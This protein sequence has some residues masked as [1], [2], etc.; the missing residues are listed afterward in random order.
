[1]NI[2]N[3]FSER[4]ETVLG[5]KI[6]QFFDADPDPGSG[7]EKF[8]SGIRGKHPGSAALLKIVI[9]C[10]TSVMFHTSPLCGIA[11][12]HNPIYQASI[13]SEHTIIS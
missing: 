9:T 2:P 13:Q 4:L 7:M 8:G 1:M 10:I 3:R 6:V 5:L 11:I 12:P